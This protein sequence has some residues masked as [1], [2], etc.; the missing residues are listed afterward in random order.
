M[1]TP[2]KPTHLPHPSRKPAD[3][4]LPTKR[5]TFF[6][7]LGKNVYS[8]DDLTGHTPPNT[9]LLMPH[10]ATIVTA[11]ISPPTAPKMPR[12]PKLTLNTPQRLKSYQTTN[13][14]LPKEHLPH[15]QHPPP[16]MHTSPKYASPTTIVAALNMPHATQITP[17]TIP[18]HDP[19][20]PLNAGV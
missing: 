14:L 3:Q 6:L 17:P 1:K 11:R 4:L 18:N 12:H 7:C 8:S 15:H 10:I 9:T 20:Q 19:R 5:H 16:E 2:L 13:T